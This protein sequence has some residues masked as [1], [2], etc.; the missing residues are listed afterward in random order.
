M[1]VLIVS[2]VNQTSH[3]KLNCSRSNFESRITEKVDVPPGSCIIQRVQN[4]YFSPSFLHRVFALFAL[5]SPGYARMKIG[6]SFENGMY[7]SMII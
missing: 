2:R 3:H 4:F 5:Q 7:S 1:V 6:D